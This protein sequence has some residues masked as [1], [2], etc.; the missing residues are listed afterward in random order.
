MKLIEL[1]DVLTPTRDGVKIYNDVSMSDNNLLFKGKL[2]YFY[3]SA[4]EHILN[5]EVF[6]IIPDDFEHYVAIALI[7]GE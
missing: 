4:P 1:L 7:K 2:S 6:Q 5:S 3:S